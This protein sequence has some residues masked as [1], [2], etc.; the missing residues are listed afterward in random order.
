M[1]MCV[2]RRTGTHAT[3]RFLCPKK[4]QTVAKRIKILAIA[5]RFFLFSYFFFI[6]FYSSF[7]TITIKYLV[8]LSFSFSF[9]FSFPFNN[10]KNTGGNEPFCWAQRTYFVPQVEKFTLL[11]DHAVSASNG[12]SAAAAE[13]TGVLKYC[14]G[15]TIVPSITDQGIG[16]YEVGDLLDAAEMGGKCGVSLD[17]QSTTSKHSLRYDGIVLQIKFEYSNTKPWQG[18]Q[19]RV[20][21]VMTTSIIN[22]TKSKIEEEFWIQYPERRITRDRHGIKI[23]VLQSG[24]LGSF[25][26]AALL[27]TLTSSLALLAVATTGVDFLALYVL[28]RKEVYKDAKY[29]VVSEKKLEILDG[30]EE[31]EERRLASA[32]RYEPPDAQISPYGNGP[33]TSVNDFQWE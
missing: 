27:V 8:Y 11:L 20:E 13:M 6:D 4:V 17:D 28:S 12:V 1:E 10:K 25:S 16:F 7:L 32:S 29:E 14:N 33:A 15:T 26:A 18:V 24:R 3:T 22:G 31:Q 19:E 23:S 30:M 9:S 5:V 21:Y 2:S